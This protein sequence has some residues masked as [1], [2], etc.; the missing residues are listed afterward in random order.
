MREVKI[1]FDFV[2][3]MI[4]N[5]WHFIFSRALSLFH[6]AFIPYEVNDTIM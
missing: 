5:D 3:I 2:E 4:A 6:K 1:H